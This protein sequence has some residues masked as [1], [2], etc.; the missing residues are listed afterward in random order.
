MSG[1]H[2]TTNYFKSYMVEDGLLNY[3][4]NARVGV[5][6][7]TKKERIPPVVSI[8][9]RGIGGRHGF[10]PEHVTEIRRRAVRQIVHMVF[11]SVRR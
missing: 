11:L 6:V 2:T 9:L 5:H 10:D 3:E 8:F 1:T 7:R 4:M